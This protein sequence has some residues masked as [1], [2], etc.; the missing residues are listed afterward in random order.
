MRSRPVIDLQRNCFSL[1]E[2]M[3]IL[4]SLLVGVHVTSMI[5]DVLDFALMVLRNLVVCYISIS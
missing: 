1:Q 5:D 3:I 4:G 2:R